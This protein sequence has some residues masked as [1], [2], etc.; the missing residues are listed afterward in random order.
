MTRNDRDREHQQSTGLLDD[1]STGP[2]ARLAD[3]VGRINAS[4]R[5]KL[6]TGFLIGA[7]LL[8]V[9]GIH[10]QF[11]LNRMSRRMDDLSRSQQDIDL[12]RQMVYSVTAKAHYTAMALLTDDDTWNARATRAK[13]EFSRH[14]TAIERDAEPE[15][16]AFFASV[17]ETNDQFT[18]SSDRVTALY[19]SGEFEQA[20]SLHI[21]EEHEISHELEDAMG[22]LI[23]VKMDKAAVATA[24][25]RSERRQRSVETWALSGVSVVLAL[26]IGSVLSLAFTR[27]LHR[28]GRALALVAAGDFKRRLVVHNRDEFGALCR[29]L[30]ET[31]GQLEG[32]YVELRSLNEDLQQRVDDQ[33]EELE[34]VT[35]L[36]RY[37]SPQ[38][39]KAIVGGETE[40]DAASRR[41]QLTVFF[42]DI[43]GFTA[44]S[45]RVE[46]EELVDV[47]NQYLDEMTQIVFKHGGTLDKYVG[48]ALMVFFGDPVPYEDHAERAV[49]CGLEML[50]RLPELQQR[51]FARTEETLGIGVGIATG[52]VTVG[53]I[54]STARLDYTVMGNNVN[55]ASRLAG[56][57]GAGQ[58]LVSERTLTA[59]RELVDSKEMDQVE[60]KG[61]SR[62]TKI[63][64]IMAKGTRIDGEATPVESRR[65]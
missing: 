56:R 8:L 10:G 6:L 58:I 41:Q 17:A 15:E 57:A 19:L 11:D 5:V 60:L 49:R 63:F 26:L 2:L 16:E 65:C 3:A 29:D 47:L 25:F 46:P 61:V 44:M 50:E 32:Q 21:D 54:G 52:Y 14:L 12:A 4:V 43:R 31:A 30:N 7:L 20:L 33:V 18:G 55:L 28:I 24:A 51:W 39:A 1:E 37:L 48:D 13:A 22:E 64:E 42:S 40:V 9:G 59:V 27:P 36:K 62:P 23:A 53:N 35:R 38:V 45:E 34:R